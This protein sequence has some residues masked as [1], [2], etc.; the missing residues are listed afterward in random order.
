MAKVTLQTIA[1]PESSTSGFT[2][3]DLHLDIDFKYTKNNEFLKTQEIKDIIADNDYAAIRNSITNLF[4]TIPGQK[5]LNPVFGLNL[6]Q[7]LFR[8]CDTI[9]ANQ[10]AK[11][12]FSGIT[13]FEP[14]VEVLLVEVIALNGSKQLGPDL[15]PFNS[16]LR[17]REVQN[18]IGDGNTYQVN[19][20][21]RI[22]Q[23]GTGSFQ[24]VGTLSNSGFFFNN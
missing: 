12:I 15:N 18:Q 17:Q 7:Y 5:I 24:L 19:L 21:L 11:E 14:R 8:P 4:L 23:I 10:I 3:S 1:K 2:Y 20:N 6:F 13:K 16:G 22:P 9:T